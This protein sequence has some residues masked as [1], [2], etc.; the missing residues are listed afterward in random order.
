[1]HLR[2]DCREVWA[3]TTT[4]PLPTAFLSCKF[5]AF[6][7]CNASYYSEPRGP[8]TTSTAATVLLC[9]SLRW[10]L[11]NFCFH[12]CSSIIYDVGLPCSPT[13]VRNHCEHHLLLPQKFYIFFKYIF[14]PFFPIGSNMQALGSIATSASGVWNSCTKNIAYITNEK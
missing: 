10:F 6:L 1:M 4:H 11:L 13:G 3:V 2:R 9:C 8:P 5:T 7:S 14:M 12:L